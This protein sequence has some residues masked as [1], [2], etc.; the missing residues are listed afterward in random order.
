MMSDKFIPLSYLSY[1]LASLLAYFTII[2]KVLR[3]DRAVATFLKATTFFMECFK[4]TKKGKANAHA[5]TSYYKDH[6]LFSLDLCHYMRFMRL[7]VPCSELVTSYSE[8]V[9]E[10]HGENS[11]FITC[12]NFTQDMQ[13]RS[14]LQK[15]V[16]EQP[17]DWGGTDWRV[18]DLFVALFN[19]K[20]SLLVFPLK[21]TYDIRDQY[22]N[23]YP[24]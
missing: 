20:P 9:G 13:I 10:A 17:K 19:E 22:L 8:L 23:E 24:F 4:S 5:L 16:T 7:C 1:Q 14:D 18:W 3:P 2:D 12:G 6:P 21:S 11:S 15:Q